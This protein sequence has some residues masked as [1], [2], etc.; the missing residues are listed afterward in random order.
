MF[1]WKG[2]YLSEP[3]ESYKFG[4][5]EI[6]KTIQDIGTLYASL[7]NPYENDFTGFI[8]ALN[9]NSPLVW[10]QSANF[11]AFWVDT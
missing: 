3:I 10:T 2:A 4:N 7:N 8:N 1:P 11:Y 5:S 9:I 6:I